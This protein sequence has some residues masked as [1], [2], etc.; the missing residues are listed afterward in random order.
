[1]SLTRR[2]LLGTAAS[3]AP[4]LLLPTSATAASRRR[5]R[6]ASAGEFDCGVMAG[7][8]GRR[9]ITVWTHVQGLE[10]SG[11]VRL[12][13]AADEGF[14]RVVHREL[15]RAERRRDFTARTTVRTRRLQPGERYW[16]RFETAAGS[17]AVGRFTTARPTDSR[18][19]LRIGFWSCQDWKD[20]LY[21][22][23]AGLAQESDL[24]LILC[25]G[26]YVYESGGENAEIGRRDDVGPDR[27][28]QTLPE[29]REKYRLYLS[30]P[31]L[32]AMHASA[33]FAGVWDDHEAENDY[34]GD[35]PG[36]LAPERRR[37]DF[38]TR[39]RN[40]YRAFFEYGPRNQF[41]DERSRIYRRIRLGGVADVLLLDTRQYRGADGQRT[42]LG[43][44]QREWLKS[45]LSGSGA[46]WKILANQVMMMALEAAPGFPLNA[47]QWD[48]YPADRA[49][50]LGHVRENGI[51]GVTAVTGDIH[52]FFAGEVYPNG[53]ADGHRPPA[54]E[55]IGGSIS[56]TGLEKDF[57][58]GA[59]AGEAAAVAA[60]TPHLK[61]AQ[62]TRRGYGVLELTSEELRCT[63]RSPTTVKEH[64][65]P[66]ETLARF[67][68]GR[69]E[70]VVE[71]A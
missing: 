31:N 50:V 1:M 19:P 6:V 17:S 11:H 48:G 39:R 56:S 47:D 54:T 23:H 40:G 65:A 15:V 58:Q 41:P 67:R 63:F 8:P 59:T 25:L 14:D 10:R 49:E 36:S 3:A 12:E 13:I 30:D 57:G 32:R 51:T 42:I 55:F 26:D 35:Q 69:E 4:A 24:D 64:S 38:A 18:E 28:S 34:E 45:T 71:R 62:L 7:V 70:G 66:I 16:Y 2:E 21:P 20:A 33:A 5:P 44:P 61:Y 52:S 27:Q 9:T 22:A 29:W 37:V 46:A 53:R 60:N 43:A 68:V